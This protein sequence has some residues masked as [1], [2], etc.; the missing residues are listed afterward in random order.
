LQAGLTNGY[1]WRGST[2]N[3]NE[4]T[5]SLFIANNG[6]VGIGTTTP[7]YTLDIQGGI[8]ARI[9]RDGNSAGLTI[10]S[11]RNS[12]INSF[13][14]LVGARGTYSTPLVSQ[15]TDAVGS[16]QFSGYDGVNPQDYS[17]RILGVVD[18][19][20]SSGIVPLA[21]TFRTGTTSLD[22]ERMRI[23][24]SGNI[25]IGDDVGKYVLHDVVRL[26]LKSRAD[27]LKTRKLLYHNFN[28]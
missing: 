27:S 23:T 1:V 15:V 26:L 9:L 19:A 28:I 13:L 8:G 7:A 11:Y 3:L 4:A 10:Q 24:S 6:S 25:G 21:L 5:S 18:S 16:L 22:T 17:A 20:V 2:S 12:T 14:N